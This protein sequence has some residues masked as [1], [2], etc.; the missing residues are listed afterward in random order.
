MRIRLL[1]ILILALILSFA[2]PGAPAAIRGQ[3]S[4]SLAGCSLPEGLQLPIGQG[5]AL[6]CRVGGEAPVIHVEVLVDQGVHHAADV[7]PG[8]IVSWSWVPTQVGRQTF[9]VFRTWDFPPSPY[10]CSKLVKVGVCAGG[11]PA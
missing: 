8:D 6:V 4:L 1:A 3:S 9:Y 11:V 7:R 10:P 5:I 2:F